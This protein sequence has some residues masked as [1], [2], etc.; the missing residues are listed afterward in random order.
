MTFVIM[1]VYLGVCQLLVA[2]KGIGLRSNLAT[3]LGMAAPLSLGF[4]ANVVFESREV[5]LNQG[6]PLLLAGCVGPLAGAIV[7][8][9]FPAR[10]TSE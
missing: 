7:A 4:V 2:A 3:L 8:K 10:K 6:L 5:I 1:G 9:A